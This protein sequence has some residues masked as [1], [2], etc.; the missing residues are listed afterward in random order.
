MAVGFI[1]KRCLNWLKLSP[2][3]VTRDELAI[4]NIII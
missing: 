2:K 4:S 1:L 3:G